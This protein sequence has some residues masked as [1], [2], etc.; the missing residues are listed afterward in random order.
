MNPIL[1]GSENKM[2]IVEYFD[3]L[4]NKIDLLVEIYISDNQR[5]QARI[6][7]INKAREEWI[8]EVDECQAQNLVKLEEN[9]HKDELIT[10]EQLFKRYC[11]LIY[12]YADLK[13]SGC[14]TGRF[15]STDLYL[16]LGQIECFQELLKF[17]SSENKY[18][19]EQDMERE[20]VIESFK[21][22]FC[23][24]E[25]VEEVSGYI[26]I[27]LKMLFYENENN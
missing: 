18:L 8:K 14:F 13:T 16:K 2:K 7:E 12:S 10:D 1:Y 27:C 4:K 11:F 15:I 6:D 21:R 17:T 22:I 24:A 3:D 9:D 5:D 20:Q 23:C 19:D 25:V 26:F